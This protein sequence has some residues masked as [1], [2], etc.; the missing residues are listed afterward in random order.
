MPTYIESIIVNISV[1][2]V[3][4]ARKIVFA[5]GVFDVTK[6]VLAGTDLVLANTKAVRGNT[7]RI[8]VKLFWSSPSQDRKH[9]SQNQN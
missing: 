8:S 7:V 2:S 6:A 4:I 9:P 1:M 3:S 5:D